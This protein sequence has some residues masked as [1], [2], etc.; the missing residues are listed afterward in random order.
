MR[1]LWISA[2]T[3]VPIS[4]FGASA[5]D[6]SFVIASSMPPALSEQIAADSLLRGYKLSSRLNPYYLQADFNGDGH[7]DAAVL[8]NSVTTGK[9]GIAI[10]HAGLVPSVV[11][12]ADRSFGNGGDDFSWMDAWC[13]YPRGPVHR[14]AD[15]ADPPTLKGD[16]LMVLKT[17]AASSIVYWTGKEYAW[18][19]QG[20]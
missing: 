18:Y 10:V 11:L 15:E 20:D 16:G 12:G 7:V 2:L 14:G 19:Q 9:A 8:V 13:V 5:E 4:L 3:M 6:L 17:E 1:G